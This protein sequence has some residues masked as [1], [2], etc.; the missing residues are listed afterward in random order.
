MTL[1]YPN[2]LLA[3]MALGGT[4]RERAA[5]LG[6][7]IKSLARYRDGHIPAPLVRLAQHPHLL[8]ALAADI[9]H[10]AFAPSNLYLSHPTSGFNDDVPR[11]V[12]APPDGSS[13][14]GVV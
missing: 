13:P 9:E 12:E 8:R 2:F 10:G 4:D 7:S 6:I 14:V 3:L 5:A 11:H 1:R